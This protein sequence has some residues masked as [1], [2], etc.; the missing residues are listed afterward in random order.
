MSDFIKSA[1]EVLS[2][3]NP[4]FVEEMISIDPASRNVV[5]SLMHGKTAFDMLEFL[6]KDRRRIVEIQSAL[7]ERFSTS[8]NHKLV[9]ETITNINEKYK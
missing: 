4:E 6:L 9:T 8:I 5:N 2:N 1:E 3:F 7:I